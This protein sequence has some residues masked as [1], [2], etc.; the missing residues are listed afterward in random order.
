MCEPTVGWMRHRRVASRRR[1]FVLVCTD[2]VVS[3]VNLGGL[4]PEYTP[5]SGAQGALL[6]PWH[7]RFEQRR[8]GA[9]AYRRRLGLFLHDGGGYTG[10]R[11]KVRSMKP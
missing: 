4:I 11:N 1:L 9:R 10:G 6:P 7:H 5:L 8:H 2:E 3:A